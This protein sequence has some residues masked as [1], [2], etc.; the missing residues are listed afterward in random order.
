MKKVIALL[1][2]TVC[3]LTGCM[4]VY[5]EGTN[6]WDGS[7]KWTVAYNPVE[8]KFINYNTV[9]RSIDSRKLYTD[10]DNV[11]Y[12]FDV[13]CKYYVSGK[14]ELGL[15]EIVQINDYKLDSVYK[16]SG[17]KGNALYPLVT[18]RINYFFLKT[19]YTEG[20]VAESTIVEF[21]DNKLH[22]YPNTKGI[23]KKAVIYKGKLVYSCYNLDD[24]STNLYSLDYSSY[25]NKPALLQEGLESDDLFVLND[26]LYLSDDKK[27]YSKKGSLD[28]KPIN[29][30]DVRNNMLIQ[31]E[32]SGMKHMFELSMIDPVS[33]VV[34]RKVKGIYGITLR[35][36]LLTMYGEDF[37]E[38]QY[39]TGNLP[40]L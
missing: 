21:K 19:N 38:F 37:V 24:K 6:I 33:G 25:M 18:D 2:I 29:Y 11:Q 3:L 4:D 17:G 32:S 12:D 35:N 13:Q 28:K 14:K 30:Y 27:M 36:D 1:F 22:E 31:V 20:K 34:M 39:L 23:I 5:V 10:K 7:R 26:E 8:E 40:G 16:Y 15:F 9:S